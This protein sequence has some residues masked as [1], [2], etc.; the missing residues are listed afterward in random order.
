MEALDIFT[1]TTIE[2]NFGPKA[3]GNIVFITVE[4]QTL[5]LLLSHLTSS[6][7]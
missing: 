5:F 2:P 3:G 7:N 6:S 4:T 1:V